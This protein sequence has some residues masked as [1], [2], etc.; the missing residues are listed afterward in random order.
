MEGLEKKASLNDTSWP[1]QGSFRY[2]NT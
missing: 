2:L 1:G